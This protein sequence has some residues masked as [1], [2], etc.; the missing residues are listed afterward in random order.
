MPP[1]NSRGPTKP[2]TLL[3]Q[4]QQTGSYTQH[5]IN[6]SSSIS[7]SA[8]S[9]PHTPQT[10]LFRSHHHISSLPSPPLSSV[11]PPSSVFFP[12][13][14][15]QERSDFQPSQPPQSIMAQYESTLSQLE[16]TKR[17][18]DDVRVSLALKE[19]HI[20]QLETIVQDQER[21]LDGFLSEREALSLEMKENFKENAELQKRLQETTDK[22]GRLQLEN[23]QLIEQVQELRTKTP[24][25]QNTVTDTNCQVNRHSRHVQVQTQLTF[26]Q[27]QAQRLQQQLNQYKEAA[28]VVVPTDH[29]DN[30]KAHVP[31]SRQGSTSSPVKNNNSMMMCDSTLSSLL[32]SV[33]TV[34]ATSILIIQRKCEFLM[35][36][37]AVLQ[38]GYDSL[39]QEKVTLEL[40]LDLMQRQHQYHQQQRQKRRES[41]QQQRRSSQAGQEQSSALSKALAIMVASS[42]ETNLLS[43]IPSIPLLPTISAAEQ[44]QE[45]ARIQHELEQA[46][47][48]AQKRQRKESA[49]AIRFSDSEELKHLEHLRLL[50][51][52]Q[53]Q[54]RQQ[55]QQ[56]Q[57]SSWEGIN[58]FQNAVAARASRGFMSPFK[59]HHRSSSST[60]L[61]SP[62]PAASPSPLSAVTTPALHQHRQ[63][64]RHHCILLMTS[65]S[66]EIGL[67]IIPEPP[68]A[69]QFSLSSNLYPHIEQCSC[70][71][72]SIIEL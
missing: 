41:Q 60:L 49:R 35:D 9:S 34:A 14:P 25:A 23:R 72:G 43:A 40:Q 48:R 2:L 22:V 12:R 21:K 66:S 51:E 33:A 56:Q 24:E 11:E 3:H 8:Q 29:R 44:E 28:N 18:L 71:L 4:Y 47:I 36:Q 59:Q 31:H 13:S 62:S 5:A 68:S 70:C 17:E 6:S 52:Q 45:K 61:S 39:R 1:S 50:N 26:F 37:I 53:E 15:S 20:R 69:S 58:I 32:A 7:G 42:K 63:H 55:Q 38:R 54:Q 19:E 64:H 57:K 67:Q 16:D 10:P 65:S 30:N 46:Q 27:Q